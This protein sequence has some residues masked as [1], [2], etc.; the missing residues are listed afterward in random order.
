MPIKGL[1]DKKR[2]PRL[3]KIHLGIREKNDRGAEYPK[4]TDYFV[5]PDEI[6]SYFVNEPQELKIM[7]PTEF[8][9]QWASTYYRSYSY[10]QGL[11]CKG[12]GEEAGRMV[13]LNRATIVDNQTG[14]VLSRHNVAK[15]DLRVDQSDIKLW[16]TANRETAPEDKFLY[17]G[18]KCLGQQCPDYIAK[19]CRQMMMLQ[20]L[21]PE[22]PGLGIWQ[23]DTTS[24]NSIENIYG[25][26]ELIKSLTGRISLIPLTLKLQPLEVTPKE[27]NRRDTVYVLNLVHTLSLAEL[28][29]VKSLPAI[30]NGDY[31]KLPDAE[32]EVPDHLVLD[33]ESATAQPMGFRETIPMP[34]ARPAPDKEFPAPAPKMSAGG[35]RMMNSEEN[36]AL[37]TVAGTW[38]IPEWVLNKFVDD[39]GHTKDGQITHAEYMGLRE[40]LQKYHEDREVLAQPVGLDVVHVESIEPPTVDAEDAQSVEPPTVGDVLAAR[41]ASIKMPWETFQEDVLDCS[42]AD[43]KKMGGDETVAM[44]RLERWI[45]ETR[46]QQEETA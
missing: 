46:K 9:E 39:L 6:K 23:I 1:T 4:K 10:T 44:R 11:I 25:A 16:P 42:W 35:V 21:L 29:A 3:G 15:L 27:T 30:G 19:N 22:V 13:D 12:D 8:E 28:G 37:K 43:Y 40:Q 2:M 33:N 36:K 34:A 38:G 24:F 7:F 17:H 5:V 31:A 32:D 18:M 41:L 14:E 20:F 45:E 26:V